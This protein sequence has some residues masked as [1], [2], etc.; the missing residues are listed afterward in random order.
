MDDDQREVKLLQELLLED[1]ELHGTG[2]Q[3]QFKWKNIGHYKSFNIYFL[4]SFLS[5]TDSFQN[6]ENVAKNEDE[7]FYYE[8]E[9]NEEL[10]KIRHEREI[11]L[12]KVIF[13][14]EIFN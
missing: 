13:H 9:C 4:N 3:R 12:Q 1:G 6:D 11:F 5:F 8:T 2:R 10:G 14:M 7:E